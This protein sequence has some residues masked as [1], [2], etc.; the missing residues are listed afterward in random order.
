M[1][2]A[3]RWLDETLMANGVF[4]ATCGIGRIAPVAVPAMNRAATRL[5]GQRS[6]SDASPLVFATRRSVRFTEMEYAIGAEQ[7]IEAFTELQAVIDREGW[8]I[9]FP[10]EVRFAA[11][12]DLW[13]STAYQRRSAYIAVH[14]VVGEDPVPYFQAVEQIMCARAGRPHWGKMHWRTA[15]DLSQRYPRFDDFL[16]LRDGL[17]PQGVFTNDYLRRVLDR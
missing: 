4:R 1:P 9:S 14:R 17:D 7:V 10:V 12:D 3:R 8:R 15:A 6:Y 5:S 13:M 11:A 16:A 2:A